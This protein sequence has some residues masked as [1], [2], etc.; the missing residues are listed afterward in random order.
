MCGILGY[1]T[2]SNED[3]E[4][5]Q[6]FSNSMSFLKYRGPDFSGVQNV[7][8]A[9]NFIAFGHSRLSI[10]DLNASANQPFLSNSNNT[11]ITFNGEIY[12][13]RKLQEELISEGCFFRTNSD[14]EVMVNAYEHWGI[15]AMLEKID[16]MFAFGLVDFSKNELIIARD[17]FGK[18]P[19]YYHHSKNHCIFSSDIRSVK[20][21][22]PKAPS[23]NRFAFGY[24]LAELATPEE[25]SIWNEIKK[26]QPG[27]Y[28]SIKLDNTRYAI[29]AKPFWKLSFTANCKLNFEDIVGTTDTLLNNAV[30]KR[31]VADVRVAALLS[32]GID[33]SLVVAKMA[34]N[35]SERINTY[36][37]V[38]SNSSFDESPYSDLVAKQFDTNHSKLPIA[39]SSLE[40][41]E[42]LIYEYGEPFADSSMIPTYL[43]SKEVSRTEKVVLGGDGGDEFFGGYDSYYKAYKLNSVK[44]LRWTGSAADALSKILPGYRTNL[45]A[46]LMA[47][48]NSPKHKLIDRNFAFNEEEINQLLGD[49]KASHAL[50]LEHKRILDALSQEGLPELSLVMNA[51]LHTRLLN[52]YLVKVDRASMYASLEMRTPFLD[53]D[54]ALFASTLTPNQLYRKGEPKAILKAV[55]SRYFGHDFIHRKKMGFSI[56][57]SDWFRNDMNKALREKLL[58]P[59]PLIKLNLNFIE[60][61]I[62]EHESEKANHVHKLWALFVFNI[63]ARKQL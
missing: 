48:A 61:L 32:G 19:L 45:F 26:L 62:L 47:K 3:K 44:K 18:K 37:I 4:M 53:K 51:S 12:N 42:N 52:D 17:R 20:N 36:S 1:L 59:N 54:L 34:E 14:T 10:I 6:L 2:N 27:H 49:E 22:L 35:S 39:A 63:W 41:I 28:A 23:L 46:E 16:G 56:P 58:E 30:S 57:I 7:V 29:D 40:G 9:N 5:E 15:D 43:I 50:N 8:H 33:S 21:L 55:A 31:L 24:Y 38:S 25:E 13:Y 60:K 11:L